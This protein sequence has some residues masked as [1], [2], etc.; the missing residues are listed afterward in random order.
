MKNPQ[1]RLW[2]FQSVKKLV[3]WQTDRGQRSAKDKQ[4]DPEVYIDTREGRV[5]Q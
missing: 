1:L 2:V 4:L 3:F 5:A